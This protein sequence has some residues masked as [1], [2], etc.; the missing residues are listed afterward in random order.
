MSRSDS[1][2]LTC[3]KGHVPKELKPPQALQCGPH[4]PRTLLG[5]QDF[6]GT[7]GVQGQTP[8]P[9]GP[10]LPPPRVCVWQKAGTEASCRREGV[11][12]VV[13]SAIGL[14]PPVFCVPCAWV[15]HTHSTTGEGPHTVSEREM[16][17]A[18]AVAL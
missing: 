15:W 4:S 14:R 3:V 17:L 6:G 2:R 1:G 7:W 10:A 13:L 18:E 5:G 9:A 11:D 8:L 16:P 12:S